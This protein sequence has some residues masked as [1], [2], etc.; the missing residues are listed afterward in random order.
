MLTCLAF[1]W[2]FYP[3]WLW[4]MEKKKKCAVTKITFHTT[5]NWCR[6]NLSALIIFLWLGDIFV[7]A[8]WFFF[9][10][11]VNLKLAKIFREKWLMTQKICGRKGRQ[12]TTR[13]RTKKMLW[14]YL[15]WCIFIDPFMAYVI[16]ASLQLAGGYSYQHVIL[17]CCTVSEL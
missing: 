7:S 4:M 1:G 10:T 3:E 13:L 14:Y 12:A 11:F 16:T 2:E 15:I 5:G 8:S 6:E 17:L 9:Q